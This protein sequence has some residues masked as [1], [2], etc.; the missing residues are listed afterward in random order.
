LVGEDPLVEAARHRRLPT[1]AVDSPIP[2]EV[3]G[4]EA[5]DFVGI[6]EQAAAETAVRHLLDLGH[7]R[8]A[9]MSLR[10]SAAGRPGPADL[11]LQR[12]AT[13]SVA[14]GRLEG[15]ARAMTAAGV[16]WATV[17][18]EQCQISDI[19]RGR[20]GAHALLDR[21]P[22]TTAIFAFSDPLAL[23]ARLAAHDRGL[24][25]PGDLS[26]IGFDDSAA[27]SEGITTI[28]QPLREKGRVAT[29]R[30]LHTLTDD[31]TSTARQLLPTR[32]VIR[33]STGAPP[34]PLR[35]P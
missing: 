31:V 14:K 25:V 1:V 29:E 26:I 2:G 15:A 6:D 24:A 21:A 9:T 10:L 32:L 33:N 17:P 16:N 20:A 5:F 3:P 7:R 23:G 19:E 28:H 35:A 34:E 18:V 4:T 22:D 11:R 8:L 12:R 13:A 30:L 27:P